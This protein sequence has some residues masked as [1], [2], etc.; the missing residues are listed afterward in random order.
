MAA[1]MSV[2]LTKDVDTLGRAIRYFDDFQVEMLDRLQQSEIRRRF[3]QHAISWFRD[4]ADGEVQRLH[5][6]DR[7][8]DLVGINRA[9]LREE[10]LRDG[11]DE[12]GMTGRTVIKMDIGT[13]L[14]SRCMERA[15]DLRC[16]KE[17]R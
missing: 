6:T 4:G 3:D 17:Q 7:D 5:R 16:R 1:M 13:D 14:A 2:I 10:A 8:R 15:R 11:A 12:V 9:P